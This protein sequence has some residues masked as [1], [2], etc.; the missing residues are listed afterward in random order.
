MDKRKQK[1]VLVFG[2]FDTLHNGHRFFLREARRCG[3]RLI[4]AVAPD[5]VAQVL[6]G[7][8]PR[9]LLAERLAAVRREGL[10]DRAVRGDA[11]INDWSI[12]RKLRPDVIALGYDQTRLEESVRA[13]ITKEN[14]PI[15]IAKIAARN[16]THLHSRLLRNR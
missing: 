9:Q 5:A 1:A 13:F 12:L 6:K 15:Q 11:R 16:P 2:V 8:P 4:A 14:L 3:A 10:A 7:K